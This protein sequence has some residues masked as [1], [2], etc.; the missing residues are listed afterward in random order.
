[1]AS[2]FVRRAKKHYGKFIESIQ[3]ITTA[4]FIRSSVNSMKKDATF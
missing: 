3:L 4:I 2:I 1:M